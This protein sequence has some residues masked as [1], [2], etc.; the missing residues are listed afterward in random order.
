MEESGSWENTYRRI[1][2]RH[3]KEKRDHNAIGM[4][5]NNRKQRSCAEGNND[6]NNKRLH[7]LIEVVIAKKK[8]GQNKKNKMKIIFV[9]GTKTTTTFQFPFL[10]LYFD[11]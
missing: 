4:E 9:K 11:Q 3:K 10:L 2:I 1:V 7:R 5:N 8:D 6:N